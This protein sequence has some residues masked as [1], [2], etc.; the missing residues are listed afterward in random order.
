MHTQF[1]VSPWTE[2]LS[3]LKE[4]GG[5][6]VVLMVVATVVREFKLWKGAWIYTFEVLHNP[7][8]HILRWKNIVIPPI[9]AIWWKN[10]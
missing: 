6:D 7:E 10:K 3:V 4:F 2:G 5:L 9:V 8:N 1:I